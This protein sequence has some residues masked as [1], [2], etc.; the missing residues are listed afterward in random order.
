MKLFKNT[1]G[2][3]MLDGGAIPAGSCRY[4]LTRSG[5]LTIYLLS[6]FAIY[7]GKLTDLQKEDGTMYADEEEFLLE[8]GD[9]FVNTPVIKPGIEIPEIAISIDGM[10]ATFPAIN[11]TRY[12][13]FLDLNITVLV[14]GINGEMATQSYTGDEL[15]VTLEEAVSVANIIFK[16]TQAE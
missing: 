5:F 9:F 2:Q 14:I 4:T 6:G 11:K 12:A 10:N 1:S 15:T 13:E 16:T 7:N 8:V 3:W